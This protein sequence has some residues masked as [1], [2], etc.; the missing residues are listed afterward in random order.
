MTND[1]ASRIQAARLASAAVRAQRVT[2]RSDAGSNSRAQAAA[3]TG[4][5]Q[6][7]RHE[8]RDPASGDYGR[9]GELI[10]LD[11][12]TDDEEAEF[13][14]LAAKRR[15]GTLD[16]RPERIVHRRQSIAG[17]GGGDE[18]ASRKK[19]AISTSQAQANIALGRG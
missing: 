6:T 15:A 11:D 5:A 9:L 2:E 4:G 16:G 18:S 14:N 12:L 17:E 7:T 19:T 10:A 8:R 13:E 3:V 1:N